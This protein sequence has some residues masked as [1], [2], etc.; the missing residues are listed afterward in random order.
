MCDFVY[1]IVAEEKAAKDEEKDERAKGKIDRN[2][3]FIANICLGEKP[4]VEDVREVYVE[5]ARNSSTTQHCSF[6]SENI[7]KTV[8]LFFSFAENNYVSNTI[9]E[10]KVL[11]RTRN[12]ERNN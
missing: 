10:T 9:S 12:K 4:R 1:E 8:H 6:A 2:S 3:F 11:I 7:E 5:R